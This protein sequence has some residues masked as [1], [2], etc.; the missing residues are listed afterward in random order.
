MD[1]GLGDYPAWQPTKA[2]ILIPSLA[3]PCPTTTPKTDVLTFQPTGAKGPDDTGRCWAGSIAVTRSGV[4]RCD[5]SHGIRDPC[6]DIPGDPTA[7]ICLSNPFGD[8]K[9]TRL[10][11][12]S[13]LPHDDASFYTSHPD[14]A[15]PWAF[16][17]ANGTT[18]QFAV[19]AA[20][21]NARGRNNYFCSDGWVMSAIPH[22]IPSWTTE[23]LWLGPPEHRGMSVQKSRTV[24]IRK[25][26]F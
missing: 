18:C 14:L 6:F 15:H 4:W 11:L 26:W 3:A 10:H 9:G 19:G 23:E 1:L 8:G 24:A 20:G 7:V 17:L 21:A 13:P 2:Q 16:V 12:T 25:V 5:S 22:R